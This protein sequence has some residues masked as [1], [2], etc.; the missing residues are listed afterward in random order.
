MSIK[1]DA[2]QI[3]FCKETYGGVDDTLHSE[4]AYYKSKSIA[5]PTFNVLIIPALHVPEMK[6]PRLK[7]S[8]SQTNGHCGGF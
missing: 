1:F 8:S 5:V 6:E 4:T 2:V 3:F 7:T